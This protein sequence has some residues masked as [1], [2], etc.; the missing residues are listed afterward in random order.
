MLLQGSEEVDR[1]RAFP[2]FLK[3]HQT[4]SSILPPQKIVYN[5][6]THSCES[7]HS[8][9]FSLN[10]VLMKCI[11]IAHRRVNK[12]CFMWE[13]AFSISGMSVMR[14][15]LS[16]SL[17]PEEFLNNV[18]KLTSILNLLKLLIFTLYFLLSLPM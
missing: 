16:L 1:E 13:K 2:M 14:S 4:S 17:Y 5:I 8:I 3:P 9:F 10:P 18:L 7:S 12:I 6:E 15:L 11:S